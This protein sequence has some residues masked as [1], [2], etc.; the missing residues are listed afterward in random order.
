LSLLIM[1]HNSVLRHKETL[2][3]SREII[4]SIEQRAEEIDAQMEVGGIDN[5]ALL[6]NRME[7]YKAK[8]TQIE[9][10][11]N[12]IKAMHEL[13]HLLQTPHFGSEINKTVSSWLLFIEE[14]KANE[15]IE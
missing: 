9:I 7:F 3:I 15:S 4:K 13:E 10:Y 5:V 14:K 8:Q 1:K 2:E 11:S 12:A 6:R